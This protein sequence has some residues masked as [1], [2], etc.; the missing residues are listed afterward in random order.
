MASAPVCHL[1]EP[2][3]GGEK[4]SEVTLKDVPTS[5]ALAK[6]L[7]DHGLDTSHWGEGDTKD[8]SKFWKEIKLN[9]AGAEVWRKADGTLQPVRVTH[10]LRAKVTSAESYE[11]GIFLFNTW[12]QYGDGRTRTRNGLLSE[13]LCIDEMPLEEHLHEV[14]VR[15][16]TEEEMQRVVE[17]QLKI[18]P[19]RPAP[20]YDPDYKCPLEVVN[21]HFVDHIIEIETSKS[22]PGLL[23]MYHLYTVEI[24]C[25]GL[26]I[27][28]LNTLEFDHPDKD[29][30]RKLK[31]VHAWVWLEWSKIQ[32]YLF[33][34]SKLKERKVRGSFKDH[35][36]LGSWLGQFNLD[37]NSWGKDTFKSVEALWKE[38][39][40]EETQLELW[41]RT[42]GVPLLV[43]VAHV[44]QLQVHTSDV[45]MEDKFLLNTWT[46]M[47]NGKA[48][49]TNRLLASKLSLSLLPYDEQ[50]FKDQCKNA[51][52]EQLA[53]LVDMHYTVNP[54][55][56]P[57]TDDA[58]PSGVT[59]LDAKFNEHRSEVEE[60]PSYKGL[61]TMYHLYFM[62]VK[63][64]DLPV[65]DFASLDFRPTL[66][67]GKLDENNK[68]LKY[69]HGW[70][71]VSW[72]QV[73]DIVHNRTQILERSKAYSQACWEAQR[74][75][76]DDSVCQLAGLT[77]SMQRLCQ[78][79]DDKDPDA[80]EAAR[81]AIALHRSL[82]D[83]Q[84]A[85]NAGNKDTGSSDCKMLPPSM[86]S[87]MAEN[88]LV[89]DKFLEEA[90]WQRIQEA[91][92]KNA[93][94][95]AAK[96][97]NDGHFEGASTEQT[98]SVE[99]EGPAQALAA[100]TNA[101]ASGASQPAKTP[102]K[103]ESCCFAMFKR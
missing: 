97:L 82:L 81:Y 80:R 64:S 29:G 18:G 16:V 11:R 69:A 74:K 44:L 79:N 90:Q 41:G 61:F 30:K 52:N 62:K 35:L 101:N 36:A 63:C 48:R 77:G 49:T 95:R 93:V 9:E 2:L 45:R 1:P 19:G 65:A 24:I 88:T 85:Y 31:Y 58:D 39:E 28:D 59:V 14:C 7:L 43:R 87:K 34:G 75:G 84:A 54:Q 38:I 5:E 76:L 96:S 55:R 51:I 20:E 8:V 89:A 92:A 25:T 15:A 4:L 13:K 66:K 67:E 50:K 53:Y 12:Q 17:S 68:T 83:L 94:Q 98:Q 86:V 10:V 73:L 22:Y 46:Q 99:R 102:P 91:K 71:W 70:R 32:R 100:I 60:S 33:E 103:S 21:E 40:S 26:P 3:A 6:W 72:P 23:T 42:D 37:L 27:V 56:L 78:K 47:P 57:T